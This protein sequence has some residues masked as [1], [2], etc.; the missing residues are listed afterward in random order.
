[1]RKTLPI[2]TYQYPNEQV[3][4]RK[5]VNCTAEQATPDSGN[6]LVLRRMPGIDEWAT[7]NTNARGS[8]VF[9]GVL[10]VVAGISLYKIASNG[11]TTNLGTIPGTEKVSM[12]DNGT[13]L[14]IVTNPDAYYT[15]GTAI[16][17]QI[18]D[19][20]F[21]G[22]GANDVAY[23]DGYFIF[24]SPNSQRAFTSGLNALTFDALDFTSVDGSPDEL[25]GLIVDHREIIFLKEYSTELWYNAANPTGFPMSRSPNGYLEIGCASRDTAAKIGGSVYWLANDGTVRQLNGNTPNIVSSVG[26]SRFITA[27]TSAWGFAYTFEDKHYYCLQTD[28]STIEYDIIGQEWHNRSTFQKDTWEC[29]DIRPAYGFQMAVNQANGKVG[30]L[31]SSTRTEW[32]DVQKIEW[33]YQEISGEGARLFHDRFQI[34]VGTG[35]GITSGQ[36]AEPII[37][38]EISDDGGKQFNHFDTRS[39]GKIGD[40]RDRVFWNRL[41][42]SYARVYRCAMTD[43]V[44]LIAFDTDV[45]VRRARF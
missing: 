26:I 43:P 4:A 31:N 32:G 14:V 15:D 5:L 44:D 9:N 39:L 11:S 17:T 45:E 20:T 24:T 25:V 41:G 42:S 6:M 36:G 30:K 28:D 10:Y 3:S 40:Y 1:M 19:S 8:H 21:I 33:T 22:W 37:E 35:V 34:Q 12:A 16:V 27:N 18:T 23:M 2:G 7:T 38:L 13:N 29:F